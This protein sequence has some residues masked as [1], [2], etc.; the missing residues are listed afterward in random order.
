MTEKEKHPMQPF[1]TI[2]TNQ[3]QIDNAIPLNINTISGPV[4]KLLII[5]EPAILLKIIFFK[6][7]YAELV[8]RLSC[9]IGLVFF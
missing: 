6:K 5:E 3:S 8:G 7:K 9:K 4:R 2:R 1:T